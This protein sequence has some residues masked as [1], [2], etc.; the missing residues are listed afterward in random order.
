MMILNNGE[1]ERDDKGNEDR[2][3]DDNTASISGSDGPIF[4]LITMSWSSGGG[5]GDVGNGAAAVAH[6]IS[7]HLTIYLSY[8]DSIKDVP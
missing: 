5:M 4:N 2:N 1:Y 7:T 8:K 3:N 6:Y